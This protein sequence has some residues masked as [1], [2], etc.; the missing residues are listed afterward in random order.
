MHM[1]RNSSV[2]PSAQWALD[3]IAACKVQASAQWLTDNYEDWEFGAI[4]WEGDG[5]N[6]ILVR[7]RNGAEFHLA[8]SEGAVIA[9][10]V[11]E[12]RMLKSGPNAV[13]AH[14]VAVA[15]T[16]QGLNLAKARAVDAVV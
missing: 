14:C 8:G 15:K 16:I 2:D 5:W 10:K 11:S 4:R 1:I 9:D 13:H 6:G 7:E 3:A 12:D